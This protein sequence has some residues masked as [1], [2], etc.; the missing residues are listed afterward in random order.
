MQENVTCSFMYGGLHHAACIR[1]TVLPEKL[2]R[3]QE[4]ATLHQSLCEATFEKAN[5]KRFVDNHAAPF[6]Y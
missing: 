2:P 5:F 3:E 4:A 6:V 1:I